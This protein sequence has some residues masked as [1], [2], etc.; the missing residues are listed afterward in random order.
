MSTASITTVEGGVTAPQGYQAAAVACGLKPSGLDLA[1]LVSDTVATAAGIFTTNRAVAAPVVLSQAQLSQSRGMAKAIV[2][3]SKCANACTGDDGMVAARAMVT[4]TAAALGC[5]TH[6][7]LIAS[8]GVIGMRL[9]TDKVGAGI[10]VAAGQ[11]QPDVHRAAAEAIMTTDVSPKERAVAV[12]TP[13]GTFT[14]GGMA[15]GAG[16]IEPNMATMLG[17][18]TTDAKVGSEL[19]E[20]ALREVADQTF[21]AITVDGESST[22]DTVFLLANGASGLAI[23][24]TDNAA[25]Y[26]AFIEGLHAVC[27]WLAREIVRGGEGATKLAT[28]VV[29]GA[30]TDDDAKR[31]ARLIANSPLVKTALN[32]GDPNWGRI[33]AVAGRAGVAFDQNKTKVRIGSTTL[34]ADATVFVD[35]EPEAAAHLAGDEVE[36]SI[37]LGT[38]GAGSATM[39]TCDFSADYVHINADYRT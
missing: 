13:S 29:T 4:E 37:D 35:R 7:V 18:L 12:T 25:T 22:N 17:F 14:V 30:A 11:L 15:K 36:V 20:E 38:G 10:R 23:T 9:D 1:L 31:A 2:V 3:N 39:W 32:G 19:L 16:M 5:E 33:V 27:S 34:F 26:S 21:N 8:T 24:D 28:V 6:H